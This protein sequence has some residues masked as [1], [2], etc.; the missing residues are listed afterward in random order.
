[1]ASDICILDIRE[2]QSGFVAIRTVFWITVVNPYPSPAAA[3][4]YPAIQTDPNTNGI[5]AA[6][7]AGTI[8]EEVNS[9]IFPLNW[10]STQWATAIEP[11]LLAY[12]NAR[13]AVRAGT[14]LALPE[15]GLKYKIVHDSASGWAA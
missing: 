8:L 14:V 1:M 6:I 3:S 9:F 4:A 5:L 13:K 12:L 10:V 7:Q 11:L 2:A 15:P